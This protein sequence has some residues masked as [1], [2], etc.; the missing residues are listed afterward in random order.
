M[1]QNSRANRMEDRKKIREL[2]DQGMTREQAKFQVERDRDMQEDENLGPGKRRIRLLKRPPDPEVP[3]EN[4]V[5]GKAPAGAK[6]KADKE[7]G[8]ADINSGG[9]VAQLGELNKKMDRLITIST[10]TAADRQK[11]VNRRA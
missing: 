6:G 9:A 2:Q 10:P 3:A 4:R 1:G 8:G 11:P 7:A 5:E